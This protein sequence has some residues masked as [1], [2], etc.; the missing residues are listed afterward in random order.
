MEQSSPQGRSN[1]RKASQ[2]D[3]DDGTST[4][5]EDSDVEMSRYRRIRLLSRKVVLG[6]SLTNTLSQIIEKLPYSEISSLLAAA[7][8]KSAADSKGENGEAAGVASAVVDDDWADVDPNEPTYCICNQV[9]YGTM[10]ACEND[11]VCAIHLLFF[12]I[13]AFR[14]SFP[15]PRSR[16]DGDEGL[17]SLLT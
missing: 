2:L 3:S 1:K 7:Q 5:R 12:F 10:I 8:P 16:L 4:L 13:I 11:E 6:K 14:F 15:W 9:S 17:S